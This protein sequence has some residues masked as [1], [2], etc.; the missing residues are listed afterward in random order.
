MVGFF[1]ALNGNKKQHITT[2]KNK[3]LHPKKTNFNKLSIKVY[4]ILKE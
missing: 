3:I 4:F 2:H 1:Y